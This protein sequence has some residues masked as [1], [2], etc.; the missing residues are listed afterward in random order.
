MSLPPA[1]RTIDEIIEAV[2]RFRIL[3]IGRSGVGKS[4]LINCVFGIKIASVE[5]D[6]VGYADIEKE[7]VSEENKLFVLHDSKGFESGDHGNFDTVRS[8]VEERLQKPLLKDRIHGIWLCVETPTAGGRVFETGDEKLLEF[9]HEKGVP[10]VLV[11]T[12]YDR[13]ERTKAKHLR[14]KPNMDKTSLRHQSIEDAEEAFETCLKTLK[15]KPDTPMPTYA[16][17]SVRKGYEK[18]VSSLVEITGDVAKA[19]VEGDAWVLW[20]LTQRASLPIKIKA[21]IIKGISYYI[22]ALAGSLSVVRQW[23]L[24]DCLKKVHNDIITCWNFKDEGKVLKSPEFQELMFCLVDG[25]QTQPSAKSPNVDEAFK[26][27][28]LTTF[29]SASLAGGPAAAS[30]SVA[31]LPAEWL[32]ITLEKN[33]SEAGRML[34]TYIVDLVKVL[35]ELFGITLRADLALTTRREE[36]HQAF[37]AYKTS[38]SCQSIHKSIRSKKRW[39]GDDVGT[40][41]SHLL[42]VDKYYVSGS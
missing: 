22:Y 1:E 3:V 30:A 6:K 32:T 19:R 42:E 39:I 26:Y 38:P 23:I 9:A 36:L 2:E 40:E 14:G 21:C 10:L 27:V 33:I 11:F 13:L 7:F 8:F 31:A 5:N 4:S 29:A 12:Q 17:V 35:I 41:I 24:R 28:T 16:K 25:V 34:V 15:L 18:F 37:E 20:A